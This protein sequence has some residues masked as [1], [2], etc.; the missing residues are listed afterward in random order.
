MCL[1]LCVLA[2]LFRAHLGVD[3]VSQPWPSAVTEVHTHLTKVWGGQKQGA[4]QGR[5]DLC[6]K[7]AERRL[8][9][10]QDRGGPGAGPLQEAFCDLHSPTSCTQGGRSR[11]D[12]PPRLS[13]PHHAQEAH[14]E[15]TGLFQGS[16]PALLGLRS[17]CHL[18]LPPS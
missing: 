1:V 3:G 9:K 8:E 7:R 2:D 4:G 12:W 6:V 18:P 16:E 17:P 10:Q 15:L 5:D 14:L 11:R 13:P